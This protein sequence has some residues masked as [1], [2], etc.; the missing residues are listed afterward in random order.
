MPSGEGGLGER[1]VGQFPLPIYNT[2]HVEEISL[3]DIAHTQRPPMVSY[4][5]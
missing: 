3:A 5:P 4:V 2:L 1:E